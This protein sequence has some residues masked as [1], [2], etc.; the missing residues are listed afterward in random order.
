MTTVGKTK[1][2]LIKDY[3]ARDPAAR[4]SDVARALGISLCMVSFVRSKLNLYGARKIEARR[5]RLH[6]PELDKLILEKVYRENLVSSIL[7]KEKPGA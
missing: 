2:E 3:L 1:T 7:D 5:R 6:P 4:T